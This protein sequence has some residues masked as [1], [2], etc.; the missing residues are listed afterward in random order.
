MQNQRIMFSFSSRFAAY[1]NASVI[2]QRIVQP[3]I[4]RQNLLYNCCCK[5]SLFQTVT[6]FENRLGLYRVRVKNVTGSPFL[7]H[8]VDAVVDICGELV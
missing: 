6:N 8:S 3:I 7:D 2:S 5:F 4:V 1:L